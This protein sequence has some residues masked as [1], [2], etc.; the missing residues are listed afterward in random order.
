MPV[1]LP[2]PPATRRHR[3]A[4]VL[5]GLAVPAGAF[6][7]VAVAVA[8]VVAGA[9]VPD[10]G[11][12]ARR[13]LLA[14]AFHPL[15]L[16]CALAWL[17]WLALLLAVP[18]FGGGASAWVASAAAVAGAVY[19][20]S[21]LDRNPILTRIATDSLVLGTLAASA[22]AGLPGAPATGGGLPPPVLAGAIPLFA[23]LA[24][25]RPGWRRIAAILAL[26]GA[27]AGLSRF[28]PGGVADDAWIFAPALLI[29]GVLVARDAL[30]VARRGCWLR[31]ARLASVAGF[32]A[33]A[34][35]DAAGAAPVW[36]TSF[37]A[38]VLI[39]SA[40]PPVSLGLAPRMLFAVTEG[41]AFLSHRLPMARA[42]K[43]AGFSVGVACAPGAHRA[44]IEEFGVSVHPWRI[45][46]ASTNPLREYLTLNALRRLYED[47]TP[48]LVHHVA[49]KPVVYGAVAAELAG[50]PM[51]INALIGLG[52][53]FIND[54][55]KT[56]LL[57]RVV[58]L[59]LRLTLDRPG[60]R[61]LVQN[62]DDAEM[63]VRA[64]VIADDRVAMIPGSGV[65]A[66]RFRPTP[67]PAGDAV[68]VSVVS[69]MLWD[70]GIGE[71]VEAARILRAR[72]VSATIRLIGDVDPANPQSIPPETL[73][74]WNAEGVVEWRG[75]RA[76]IEAVWA[77][78]HVALLASYREGM[79]KALLE[80]AACGR[81][82]I[83]TDAPGCRSLVTDGENGLLVPMKD[84]AAI[85]AAVARLA[86]DPAERRR[87]GAAARRRIED[88]YADPVIERQVVELYRSLSRNAPINAR[89]SGPCRSG[90]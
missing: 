16:L 41:G 48:A 8:A 40:R 1:V 23:C 74:Q 15:G 88:V 85:A 61:L 69:R 59:A 4:A 19:L 27:A 22:A 89:P 70:K 64:G 52:F 77:E 42:A 62:A 71:T 35:F 32:G 75:P 9:C 73:A 31:A 80:A 28:R 67:E 81:P 49:V 56:G 53:L 36:G 50:I 45:A 18:G 43:T 2:D 24:W 33:V 26:A 65:D 63:F 58:L 29:P 79:P 90:R 47:A 39:A 46:R 13:V 60:S 76:D 54:T 30:A 83:T 20:W 51:A 21:I 3:L 68:V 57:R 72:G 10:R 14:A 82:L 34:W 17:A 7:G 12:H 6:G 5:A 86:A 25:K 55:R 87:M 11:R 84:A 66:V 38:L 78:S 44:R 37:L